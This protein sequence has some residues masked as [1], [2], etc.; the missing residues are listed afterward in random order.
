MRPPMT[1]R[2]ALP[3]DSG[4]V[5]NHS[6]ATLQRCGRNRHVPDTRIA[7]RRAA[8]PRRARHHL[9][10]ADADLPRAG[11][12]G[13]PAGRRSARIGRWRR[14][15]GRHPG[16]QQR[17]LRR[18]AA[19]GAM[20]RRRAQPAQRPL[21]PARA[22]LRVARVAD[23]H[24]AGRRR[25]RRAGA[26]PGRRPPGPQGPYPPRRGAASRRDARLRG[27][28][29]RHPPGG[30]R[31][32]GRRRAGGDLLHRRHDRVSQRRDAQPRQPAHLDPS[33]PW[34]PSRSRI[35]EAARWWPRRCSTPRA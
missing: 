26:R 27:A 4:C 18:A 20:G 21:E 24:P 2:R 13:R 7:P 22:G 30:G 33:A 12:P 15:A 5:D 23:Q 29:R 35:R 6:T 16:A 8:H 9:R 17:P 34:Q 3:Q 19:G 1:M 25:S 31:A 32:A 14:G 28:D 10:R 11:R